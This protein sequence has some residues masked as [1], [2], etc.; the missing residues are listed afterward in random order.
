VVDGAGYLVDPSDVGAIAAGLR[1]TLG[2]PALRSAMV[3][4][5]LQRAK[6][7]SWEKCAREVLE[8]FDVVAGEGVRVAR[9][10]PAQACRAR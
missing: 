3:A 5:G 1:K 7:F 4:R 8:V 2:D 10:R 9:G 6:D